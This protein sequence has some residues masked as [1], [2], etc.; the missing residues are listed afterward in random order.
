MAFKKMSG[1]KTEVRMSRKSLERL[2]DFED[3]AVI[4]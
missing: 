4:V 1:G 2:P 3:V